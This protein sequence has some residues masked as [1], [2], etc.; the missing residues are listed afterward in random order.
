MDER[1][2]VDRAKGLLTDLLEREHAVVWPE[3]EARLAEGE[4]MPQPHL[5]TKAR[6]ELMDEG[7]ITSST[8]TT[9]GGRPVTVWHL[10]DLTQRARAVEDAAGRKRL[11]Y[12]RHQSWSS[13]RRGYPS[14]LIGP[15]AEKVVHASL[16]AAAPHGYRLENPGGGQIHRLLGAQVP[17]GPLDNAASLQLTDDLGRPDTTV[18]VPVEVKNVRSWIYPQATEPYQL[19]YKAALLQERHPDLRFVPVLICRRRS[20]FLWQMGKELGFFPIEVRS[21]YVLPRS[22]VEPKALEEVRHGL[23]YFDLK[24]TEEAEPRL[25]QALTTSLPSQAAAYAERWRACGPALKEYFEQLRDYMAPGDR[26]AI[27]EDFRDEVRH[28]PDCEGRW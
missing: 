10:L 19:L 4:R 9:R 20:Y 26:T 13:A 14:G 12:A 3:V 28:L 23:G 15:A 21:Q 5:L 7:S 17:G 18:I 22:P 8:D 25:I 24:M 6:H 2:W 27:M 11:L 1:G 16:V